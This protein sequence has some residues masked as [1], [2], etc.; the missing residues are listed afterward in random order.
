[1]ML[2]YALLR[3]A[4]VATLDLTPEQELTRRTVREFAERHVR[5]IAAKADQEKRWPAENVPRMAE[6]GLLGMNVDPQW[7]G[8]GT[9]MVSYAI[10]IEELSRACASHGVIA[11]VNNS[12]YL[13]PVLHFGTDAKKEKF[14]KPFAQGRKLGAYALSEPVA[15]TYPAGGQSVAAKKGDHYVLNGQKNFITNGGHADAYVVFCKTDPAAKH[16]G[17]SALLVEK[18]MT[19][20]TWS[21]PEHKMGI[22]AAHST[23]LYFDNVEVPAENLLGKEGD[24]F[25]VAMMTLDGGRIGI[26]AQAL[27][28]AQACLEESVDYAKQREQFGKPI[29]E[30]QAIQFKLADMAMRIQASRLLTYQAAALKDAGKKYGPA[31]AMAK[32]YAGDTAMWAATEAVQI[33]GGNGYTT[34]YAAERHFRDAKITQIYEGTNE[35]QRVVVAGAVLKG[36]IGR[37]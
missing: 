27:G 4:N 22:R 17:M 20:F 2:K 26:A 7:G 3:C 8:A 15:G 30:F 1:M 37:A 24:G 33:H 34:D 14:A 19:G 31:A 35:I 29:A 13:W 12:L 10:G 28:I 25:K 36:E 16:K 6:L 5:P 23:Q 32:C 18:G 21:E 9:G 11:S